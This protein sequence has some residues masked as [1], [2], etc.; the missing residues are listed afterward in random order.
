MPLPRVMLLLI[1]LAVAATG[2]RSEDNTIPDIERQDRIIATA[3]TTDDPSQLRVTWFPAPCETFNGVLV[4]LDDDFANL[5][6]RVTVDVET[7]PGNTRSEAIVDLGEPL[8]DREV[9]D[10][11]FN[12]T[13]ALNAEAAS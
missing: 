9:W 6:V 5:T 2:C 13:V 12:D 8:G 3:H 7:C 4:D 11:A 1:L 10:R